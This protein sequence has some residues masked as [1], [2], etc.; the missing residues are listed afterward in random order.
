MCVEGYRVAGS[1]AKDFSGGRSENYTFL[2]YSGTRERERERKR[3]KQR[4]RG[5]VAEFLW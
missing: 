2:S 5:K 4:A 3:D 1:E